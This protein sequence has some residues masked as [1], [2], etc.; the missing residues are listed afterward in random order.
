MFRKICQ[1]DDRF[2]WRIELLYSFWL[3]SSSE[4]CRTLPFLVRM[5]PLIAQPPLPTICLARSLMLMVL[6]WQ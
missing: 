4:F 6:P 2:H 1:S 3:I 5:P